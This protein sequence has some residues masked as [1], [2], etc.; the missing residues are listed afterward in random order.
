M[1]EISSNSVNLVKTST[2]S[3]FRRVLNEYFEGNLDEVSIEIIKTMSL[4]HPS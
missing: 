2:N 4:N 3:I 1:V